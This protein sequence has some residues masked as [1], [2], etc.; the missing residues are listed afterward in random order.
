M[1]QKLTQSQTSYIIIKRLKDLEEKID[2]LQEEI[3]D[4]QD[5]IINYNIVK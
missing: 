4:M 1:A 3:E 5:I 2:L